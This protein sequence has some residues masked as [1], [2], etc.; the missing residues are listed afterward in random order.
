MHL[1]DPDKEEDV[2][3]TE[4]VQGAYTPAYTPSYSSPVLMLEHEPIQST[5][6]TSGMRATIKVVSHSFTDEEIANREAQFEG[7]TTE[8][9]MEKDGWGGSYDFALELFEEAHPDNKDWMPG[10]LRRSWIKG[11]TPIDPVPSI[12]KMEVKFREDRPAVP[13][14]YSYD[15]D[16]AYAY[17]N[18][19]FGTGKEWY[20]VTMIN[21]TED[22]QKT[23]AI[24]EINAKNLK[25]SDLSGYVDSMSRLFRKPVPFT[26]MF[27]TGLPKPIAYDSK[28][29]AYVKATQMHLYPEE[30]KKW[31]G[32]Y[33]TE[34]RIAL[35]Q[36]L[37]SREAQ[38][39]ID[40]AELKKQKEAEVYA[41][42]LHQ[43]TVVRPEQTR[44][45]QEQPDSWGKIFFDV[46]TSN[47]SQLFESQVVWWDSISI[48]DK[49]TMAENA[50]AA[51]VEKLEASRGEW[52]IW[53]ELDPTG[54]LLYEFFYDFELGLYKQLASMEPID[55]LLMIDNGFRAM[56]SS[57]YYTGMLEGIAP[58]IQ[59]WGIDFYDGIMF[60]VDLAGSLISDYVDSQISIPLQMAGLKEAEEPGEDWFGKIVEWFDNPENVALLQG[61]AVAWQKGEL[62]GIIS[63]M[64]APFAE[65]LGKGAAESINE[66]Y[67][68]P[69]RE[70]GKA[71]G[72]IVG[73]LIPEIVLAIA[74]EGLAVVF[75]KGIQAFKW[76]LKAIEGAIDTA[77]LAAELAL[78]VRLMDDLAAALRKIDGLEDLA[79]YFERF[80]DDAADAL[81][82]KIDE[83]VDVDGVG[84]GALDEVADGALHADDVDPSLSDKLD[85]D[86]PEYNAAKSE[87]DELAKDHTDAD[88]IAA[89]LTQAIII[90]EVADEL[91][92]PIIAL[93][94]QLSYLTSFD[95]V[96]GFKFTPHG[97]SFSVAMLASVLEFHENYTPGYYKDRPSTTAEN[98]GQ[99]NIPITNEH[100]LRA[101]D[102]I[103]EEQVELLM[104]AMKHSGINDLDEL[105]RYIE[106]GN[107]NP[108]GLMSAREKAK[109]QQAIEE[110][111]EI[112]REILDNVFTDLVEADKDLLIFDYDSVQSKSP[113]KFT[114][115][116][117]LDLSTVPDGHYDFVIMESG[118]LRIGTD[119]FNLSGNAKYVKGA[120]G[121]EIKDGLIIKLHDQSGHY[122]PKKSDVLRAANLLHEMNVM[123]PNVELITF[124]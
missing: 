24:A 3:P 49:L 50:A 87:A 34:T 23:G 22:H 25:L 74:T 59:Q 63:T 95:G 104:R 13:H 115:S 37:M 55:Y 60:L 56:G 88:S 101:L 97:K 77:M 86:S 17:I 103:P 118:E 53:K 75:S 108:H 80:A 84:V 114:G 69:W 83:A 10:W 26:D 85:A 38:K 31:T 110:L 54:G 113:A 35:S 4:G 27:F 90:T 8:E 14:V 82:T 29:T 45:D 73:Y 6:D 20:W 93:E 119:H 1:H 44:L 16:V 99:R 79:L 89:A 61:L 58:G 117:K 92:L 11:W 66:Y 116:G 62:N 68:K 105:L 78:K 106:A 98:Y 32:I 12:Y 15:Y 51:H 39:A 124:H 72:F 47:G 28:F 100:L 122:G 76:I 123:S 52:S 36:A 57:D 91:D 67:T 7:M 46:F 71:M 21:E 42:K 5:I 96:N 102:I 41:D 109:I 70:Q 48:E 121:I 81:T 64:L 65:E 30:P 18:E 9:M 33:D 120:G 112:D 107:F 19:H 43:L 111:G 2:V 40:A 94:A